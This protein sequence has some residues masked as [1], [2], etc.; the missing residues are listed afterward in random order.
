M[1]NEL[2][3]KDVIETLIIYNIEHCRFPYNYLREYF[4]NTK[5]KLPE[6]RGLAM[7]DKKLILI[8]KE[9]GD[10]RKRETI[11]HEL[12]HTKHYRLGDLQPKNIERVVQSET[13]LTY[14]KLYGV[15]L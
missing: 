8:D 15:K 12:I 4:N 5:Y 2:S 10:E 13:L 1:I 14:Y 9:Q 11:I 6:I 7:D 3:L